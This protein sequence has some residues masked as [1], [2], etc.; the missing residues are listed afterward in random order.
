LLTL[1][2]T[3]SSI[4]ST[5]PNFLALSGLQQQQ[6]QQMLVLEQWSHIKWL[7]PSTGCLHDGTKQQA[8]QPKPMAAICCAMPSAK[9][10]ARKFA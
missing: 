3:S 10:G 2:S 7:M 1:T 9:T 8:M 6:Q 5:A 4:A